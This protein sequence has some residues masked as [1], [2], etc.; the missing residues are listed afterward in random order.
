MIEEERFGVYIMHYMWQGVS[1]RRCLRRE[2]D[3]HEYGSM[4]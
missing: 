1:A 4:E 3:V 2:Q